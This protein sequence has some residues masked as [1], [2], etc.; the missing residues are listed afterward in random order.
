[1]RPKSVE[2]H[3]ALSKTD[4]DH[5]RSPRMANID[6]NIEHFTIADIAKENPDLRKV[7]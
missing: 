3:E 1:M 2:S 6:G 4:A 7:L 5:E